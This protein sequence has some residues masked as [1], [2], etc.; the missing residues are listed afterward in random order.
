MHSRR[1]HYFKEF[2]GNILKKWNATRS[3]E[4]LPRCGRPTI[5]SSNMKALVIEQVK[6]DAFVSV[7]TIHSRLKMLGF[8]GFCQ[9]IRN[10]I[11]SMGFKSRTPAK[12]PLLSA[13]NK[14]KRVR[15]CLKF[16]DKPKSFWRRV[17][18][19]DESKFTV[20]GCYGGLKVWRAK[21]GLARRKNVLVR[22]KFGPKRYMVWGV[23]GYNGTGKMKEIEGNMKA[24]HYLRILKKY[25]KRSARKIGMDGFI[26]MQ[27]NDSK[28]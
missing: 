22:Q 26:F 15:F 2:R 10:C 6:H 16:H 14:K 28:H 17:L 21:N 24:P 12:K 11:H 13:T 23:F 5:M 27:D 20:F 9:T 8:G 1:A 19:R 3:V 18:F 4:N 25:L 7:P